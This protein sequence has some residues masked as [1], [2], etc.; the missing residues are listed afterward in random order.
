M[1]AGGGQ[2]AMSVVGA[3]V[4]TTAITSLTR[5][6]NRTESMVTVLQSGLP[7]AFAGRSFNVTVNDVGSPTAASEVTIE[8]RDAA[9]QRRGFVRHA[10]S[11]T[12]PLEHSC[13]IPAG[14]GR[15]QL[16]A[17]VMVTDA[18]GSKPI[19]GV[20]LIEANAF[21]IETKPPC[22]PVSVGG[23]AGGNCDGWHVTR[24]T[25]HKPTACP[26]EGTLL[27]PEDRVV[28]CVPHD[29]GVRGLPRLG[30]G[31][32]RFDGHRRSASGTAVRESASPTRPPLGR[33]TT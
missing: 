18:E 19:V 31:E 30:G 4:L 28:T 16:R 5:G 29:P 24:M 22:A 1:Y 27:H 12:G 20:E 2:A 8:I 32:S 23:G 14:V 17:I 13:V 11:E 7:S 9:D 25:Q 3:G 33:T 6:R 15:W 10:A 26:T 21:R